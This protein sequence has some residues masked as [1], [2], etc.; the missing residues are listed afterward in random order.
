MNYNS[1][2]KDWKKKFSLFAVSGLGF[3]LL[4]LWS[5]FEAS[6][7]FI[8]PDMI[9]VLFVLFAPKFYKKYFF[10]TLIASL[11][12]ASL[13]YLLNVYYFEKMTSILLS[14]P[15]VTDFM[16]NYIDNLYLKYGVLGTLFQAF[17][18]M[19][20]K[21]WIN[22]AVQHNLN[23][24][25]FIILTGISRIIRFGVVLFITLF[26][27]KKFGAFLK[28]HALTVSLIYLFCFIV[29][30]FVVESFILL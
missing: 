4:F 18:F 29:L 10:I 3:L 21:I 26:V 2:N 23:F 22:L 8:A 14:T 28:K 13:Y 30:L 20:L 7:W 24:L 17:S 1:L 9:L 5:F 15:F 16:I 27:K 25:S 12:G 11:L 19:S 6:F